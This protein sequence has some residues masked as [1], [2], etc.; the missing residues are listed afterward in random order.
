M[1]ARTASDRLRGS[2]LHVAA[3]NTSG[4]A[5]LLLQGTG[6]LRVGWPPLRHGGSRGRHQPGDTAPITDASLQQLG[7]RRV[8]GVEQFIRPLQ[9]FESLGQRL[10]LLIMRLDFLLTAAIS[11]RS[12]FLNVSTEF[13]LTMV[14]EGPPRGNYTA[15][16]LSLCPV[17]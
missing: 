13:I 12:R 9:S 11:S 7:N 16:W 10:D 4:T 17:S 6:C 8:L 2:G 5:D 15:S 14:P 3:A 1:L